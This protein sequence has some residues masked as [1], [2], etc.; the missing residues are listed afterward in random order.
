[1]GGGRWKFG[2]AS[3]QLKC[4]LVALK[5]ATFNGNVANCEV[6]EPGRAENIF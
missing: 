3:L 2:N 6:P 4:W 5:S 1:M